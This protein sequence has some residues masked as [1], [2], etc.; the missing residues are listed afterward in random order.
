MPDAIG[1]ARDAIGLKGIDMEDEG[2]DIPNPSELSDIDV[3]TGTFECFQSIAGS[4]NGE[5]ECIKIIN[6]QKYHPGAA[7]TAAAPY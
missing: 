2:G 6:V 7:A 3:S 5:V 1:M 4:I